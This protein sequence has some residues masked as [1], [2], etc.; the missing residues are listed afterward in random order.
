MF[1]SA[2]LTAAP[3]STRLWS[4]CA[5]ISGQVL[6]VGAMLLA[7]LISPAVLPNLRS[8]VTL[9]EPPRPPLPPR[10]KGNIEVQP[11]FVK[12]TRVYRCPLCAP[13]A[14]PERIVMDAK[15]DPPQVSNEVGVIGGVENGSTDGVVGGVLDTLM[16]STTAPPP[17]RIVEQAVVKPLAPTPTQRIRAGGLVQLAAPIFHPDP[18]YPEMARRTR[19]EGVVELEGIIGTDGRIHSL[20]VL[21]GHPFL[22]KAA[23]DAVMKWV[24]KPATLNGDLVE[25]I[26]PITVTFRLGG[27]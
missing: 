7:P 13:T 22:V 1:E 18:V 6:I 24:Y 3:A 17:R 8:Y 9:L 20:R 16:R 21:K 15:D 5:G 14:V 19:V 2:T 4:T 25:V 12:A 27:Y 10:P 11:K 26:A 23:T